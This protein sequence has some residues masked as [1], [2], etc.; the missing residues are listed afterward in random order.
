[1]IFT[2]ACGFHL[3]ESFAEQKEQPGPKSHGHNYNTSGDTEKSESRRAAIF[4]APYSNVAWHG[5]KQFKNTSSEQ[6]SRQALSQSPR[7]G[8]AVETIK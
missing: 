1:M 2:F 7:L 6:P 3:F 8:I 4:S 5:H